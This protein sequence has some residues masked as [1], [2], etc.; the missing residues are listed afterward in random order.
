MNRNDKTTIPK[1]IES[2]MQELEQLSKARGAAVGFK[3]VDDTHFETEIDS[4][5]QLLYT[6]VCGEP[7][8]APDIFRLKREELERSL[9]QVCQQ[10]REHESRSK[11][12]ESHNRWPG[13]QAGHPL[14]LGSVAAVALTGVGPDVSGVDIHWQGWMM[15]PLASLLVLMMIPLLA[16]WFRKL[17]HYFTSRQLRRQ[18]HELEEEI[19]QNRDSEWEETRRRS[20]REQFIAPRRQL[21]L[22]LYEFYKAGGVT[23]LR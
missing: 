5:L 20:Q 1:A 18:A 10:Q 6:E 15:V 21:L 16:R 3:G 12:Q 9:A 8:P 13:F 19:R 11:V 14:L 4:R 23:A 7:G 2:Q 22:S 17:E